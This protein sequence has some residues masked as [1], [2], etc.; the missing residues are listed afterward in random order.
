MNRPASLCIRQDI[1]F[2]RLLVERSWSREWKS[3]SLPFLLFSCQPDDR[4]RRQF[5]RLCEVSMH[6]LGHV[7]GSL[8][9]DTARMNGKG[10]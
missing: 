1:S 5:R 6:G 4:V 2:A 8:A 3:A 9:R 7:Q 10:V